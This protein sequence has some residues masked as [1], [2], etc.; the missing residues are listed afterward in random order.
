MTLIDRQAALYAQFDA[1]GIPY[2]THA[3]P[4]VFTVEEGAEIKARLPGGHTKNL[5]LTDKD[6]AVILISALGETRIPLNRL[7]REI[8]TKRL[9]FGKPALMQETLGVTPGSVTVFALINDAPP[10]VRCILDAALF[11]HAVVNFHPLSND[12]TTAIPGDRLEDFVRATGHEPERFDF[13][14]L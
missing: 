14:R 8:G 5:F 9:S 3:H 13:S 6:S 7:H 2:E 11:G 4:P 10:R 1:L 12:A